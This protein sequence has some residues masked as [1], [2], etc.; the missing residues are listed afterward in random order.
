VTEPD[1]HRSPIQ[2]AASKIAKANLRRSLLAQRQALSPEAWRHKSDRLCSHLQT[3]PLF[4]QA[5][6][7]LAY[8]SVRQEPDL[9]SLFTLPYQWG[10]PRCV[11]KTLTWHRWS[12]HGSYSLQTNRF[13]IPEPLPE[14]PILEANDVDLILVPAVACDQRG[15]RLGYGGGFYDRLLDSPEWVNKP[16]IGIIFDFALLPELPI[17]PWDQPLWGVCTEKGVMTTKG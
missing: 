13:N 6:T 3:H 8:F 12:P 14:A 1:S 17:D 10:F 2:D 9:I 16:T 4:I 15:Y 5:R 7:I 11:G